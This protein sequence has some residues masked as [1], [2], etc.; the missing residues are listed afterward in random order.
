MPGFCRLKSI[1]S[2][3]LYV[4]D[5]RAYTIGRDE[6]CDI[7]IG[8]ELLSRQHASLSVAGETVV[9]SDLGSTNGTYVNSMR[10]FSPTRL[11]HGDVVTLGDEKLVFMVPDPPEAD[12]ESS[13]RLND[14]L[15]AYLEQDRTSGRTM[16]RSSFMQTDQWGIAEQAPVADAVPTSGL[17][18]LGERQF[19]K[20]KTPAVLIVKN[21]RRKGTVVELRLP[22][23]AEQE[24]SLGRSSLSDVVLDDPTVSS[25]HAHIVCN[26][27]HWTIVDNH[28]TNGVK[29]NGVSVESARCR[30]G[31]DIAIGNVIL[32][33]RIPE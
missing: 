16:L 6:Q 14:E 21:G 15:A 27:G 7:H 10:I 9:L 23:G 29:L 19:D 11:H 25:E 30:S 5:Q 3:R 31:D 13:Q 18:P 2:D 33:F 20:R 22:F 1:R 8:S 32:E 4:L 24:W 26:H 12:L 17:D 28:S